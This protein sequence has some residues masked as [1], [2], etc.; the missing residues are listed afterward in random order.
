MDG[1]RGAVGKLHLQRRPCSDR[2]ARRRGRAVALAAGL[3]LAA[4]AAG[5][6]G[7]GD[8]PLGDLLQI[9]ETPRALL[10]LDAEGGGDNR[11]ALERGETV[12]W[13]GSR[14]LVGVALTDRRVLA[15]RT[16]SAAWQTTR[17]RRGEE[18]ARAAALG[19]RV[20]LVTTERRIL[21]FDG[22]S[23]NLIE[24]SV[25]PHEEVLDRRVGANL[26]VVV[27]S[28]RA[29][30]LSPFVGGFFETALR[31]G[32]SVES[33]ETGSEI[34]TLTT[35]HRLLVFRG[36]TGTWSERHLELR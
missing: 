4:F 3:G 10:A 21:G 27:T 32:E 31:V 9:V 12:L 30:G 8:T 26:A 19:D 11:E 35:S 22:G 33:V 29:L 34:A 23:G 15:V 25:G 36:R 28:R 16:R 6:A 17:W 13:K 1:A 18:P 20:A 2:A 24:S 14:G 5:A 7:P